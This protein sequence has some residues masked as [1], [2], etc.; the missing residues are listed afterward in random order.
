MD[1]SSEDNRRQKCTTPSG[2]WGANVRDSFLFIPGE[3]RPV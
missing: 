3:D 2:G 1:S